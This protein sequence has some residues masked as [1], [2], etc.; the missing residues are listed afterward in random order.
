[1]KIDDAKFKRPVYPGDTLLFKLDLISPIRRGICHMK[2]IIYVN[3]ILTTEA[4]LMAQ[5]IHRNK[6]ESK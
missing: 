4:K 1:M 6:I 3:G 2:G 5:L